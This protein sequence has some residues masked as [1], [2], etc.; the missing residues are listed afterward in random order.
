MAPRPQIRFFTPHPENSNTRLN[1]IES[2]SLIVIEPQ[3]ELKFPPLPS[4]T[5]I[6][7]T[8][9][10]A[11]LSTD[12][13]AANAIEAKSDTSLVGRVV[14]A[15][16]GHNI[17]AT[18]LPTSL[19]VGI[20]EEEF[21]A[22]G[23]QVTRAPRHLR[24]HGLPSG[25][26]IPFSPLKSLTRP[27]WALSGERLGTTDVEISCGTALVRPPNDLRFDTREL[28]LDTTVFQ[29]T[30]PDATKIVQQSC[31][32][33]TLCLL[34]HI[35]ALATCV[36]VNL[37]QVPFLKNSRPVHRSI[38]KGTCNP[39][40][41]SKVVECAKSAVRDGAPWAAVLVKAPQAHAIW[42]GD[43]AR[44]GESGFSSDAAE[45]FIICEK[46]V[47]VAQMRAACDAV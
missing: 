39:S 16:L 20:P 29:S 38:W 11:L 18:L 10:S 19:F 32:H 6:Y 40:L 26:K 28:D 12:F 31:I 22:V 2:V 9:L 1:L 43:L 46:N 45:I 33:D 13:L 41:V 42:K 47:V 30:V 37:P 17:A 15:R 8:E 3:K 14:S 24:I 21:P 4:V 23:L 44:T 7:D 34:D 5:T 25:V 36:E 27:R 35:Q